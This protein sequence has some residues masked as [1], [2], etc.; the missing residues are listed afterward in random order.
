MSGWCHKCGALYSGASHNCC[1]APAQEEKEMDRNDKGQ[2]VCDHCKEPITLSGAGET[3]VNTDPKAYH[4]KCFHKAVTEPA[5]RAA[6]LRERWDRAFYAALTGLC[7]DSRI[8][9]HD[10]LVCQAARV[11]DSAIQFH[12]AMMTDRDKMIAEAVG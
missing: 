5:E 10:V 9:S 12:N 4:R 2:M 8:Y 11:A 6:D 3:W 1:S 7:G